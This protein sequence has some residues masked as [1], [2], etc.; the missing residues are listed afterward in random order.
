MGLPNRASAHSRATH[1]GLATDAQRDTEAVP[2]VYVGAVHGAAGAG[3]GGG[4]GGGR[5]E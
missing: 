1:V 5:G 4:V 2:A 3:G